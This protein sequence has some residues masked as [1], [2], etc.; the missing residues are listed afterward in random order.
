MYTSASLCFQGYCSECRT[1]ADCKQQSQ[2]VCDQGYCV[3]CSSAA[4]CDTGLKCTSNKCV[5]DSSISPPVS[6][7]NT[8]EPE[9]ESYRVKTKRM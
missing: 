6:G 4:D 2:S 8:G 5:K 1:D 7:E 3:E 9:G